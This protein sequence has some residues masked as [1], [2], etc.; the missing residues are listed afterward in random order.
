MSEPWTNMFPD[1]ETLSDAMKA[2]AIELMP[3]PA[4]AALSQG[5]S[6]IDRLRAELAAERAENERLR[7]GNEE[8]RFAAGGFAKAIRITT[9]LAYPWPSLDALLE[10][11]DD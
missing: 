1:A 9:G 3:S 6:E 2:L 11:H 10:E 4:T 7:A 8:L 5:S